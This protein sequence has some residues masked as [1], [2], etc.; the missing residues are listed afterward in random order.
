MEKQIFALQWLHSSKIPVEECYYNESCW[1]LWDK[2][3]PYF[4][5]LLQKW[6]IASKG[7]RFSVKI[8]SISLHK[9]CIY[10][11]ESRKCHA[12]TNVNCTKTNLTCLIGLFC[13]SLGLN[14]ILQMFVFC[15][16]TFFAFTVIFQTIIWI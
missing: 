16:F 8:Q 9:R 1:L 6:N 5:F 13:F 10:S 2:F 11:M 15:V 7:L 12:Y 14:W 3:Q 4:I